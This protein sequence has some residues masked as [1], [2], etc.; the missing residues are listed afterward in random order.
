MLDLCRASR[1]EVSEPLVAERD[2]AADLARRVA[3]QRQEIATWQATIA[4]LTARVGD[5]LAGVPSRTPVK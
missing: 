3:R 5:L 1:D 2:R 4:Q